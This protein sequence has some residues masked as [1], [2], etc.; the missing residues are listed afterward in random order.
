MEKVNQIAGIAAVLPVVLLWIIHFVFGFETSV[1]ATIAVVLTFT[2]A[3]AAVEVVKITATLFVAVF[4]V[5]LACITAA[6]A[7]AGDPFTARIIAITTVGAATAAAV[8]AIDDHKGRISFVWTAVRF[9]ISAA[10]AGVGVYYALSGKT[11][12]DLSSAVTSIAL[13][14]GA[15]MVMRLLP[16]SSRAAT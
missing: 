4:S 14:F 1:S 8:S 12:A 13:A 10:A 2:L 6:F 16:T 7:A 11:F 15:A 5:A 9:F 3:Y